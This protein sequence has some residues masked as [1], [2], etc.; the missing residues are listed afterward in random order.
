M[1]TADASP[2]Q[3]FR[4]L[5]QVSLRTVTAHIG[6]VV[7][8][9]MVITGFSGQELL[10]T[11]FLLLPPLLLIGGLGP[12]MLLKW[13]V[14]R[15]LREPDP[16]E[17]PA[18]RLD[19]ILRLPQA[20]EGGLIALTALGAAIYAAVPTFYYP[21]K[22]AWAIPWSVVIVV[23]LGMLSGIHTRLMIEQVLRP[24]A[25]AEFQ[26]HPEFDLEGT[27]FT[28]PRYRWY[29]PYAFG[30]FI[31]C[32]LTV[33]FT[34]LGREAYPV[35]LRVLQQVDAMPQG[36]A[37]P[38]LRA[39]VGQ[40]LEASALPLLLLNSYV[41]VVATLSALSLARHLSEGA[42][43]VQ[44]SME[45]LAAGA[46][47][48]PQWSSTDE[49]G[50][51]A[52]AT[53]RAF[54]KLRDFSLSLRDSAGALKNSAEQLG[55]STTK[56]TEVL[57]L[58]AS[59][60]Q[61][62]QVTAQEIKQTSAMA[63][64]KAENVLRQT[65]RANE[66]SQVG[67]QAIQRTLDGLKAIQGQVNEMASRIRALDERARQIGRI[68]ESVKS[69]ADRS[70]ML[71][72]NAAIEAV[73]SGE[74][75]KGF[76][77]VAREIRSLA[78]QSI[79]ATH[80]VSIILEDISEAIRTTAAITEEG[81]AKVGTSLGEIREFGETLQQLSNIVRDNA[82]SVRQIT[83]AVNQQG[84]GI[85]QIFQAVTDLSTMMDQ[86]MAQLNTSMS[87]VDLVRDV[88]HQVSN[89]LGNYG[90]QQKQQDPESH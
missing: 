68:T 59:A 42:R 24:H 54:A 85:T 23:L 33:S 12:H 10:G 87:A 30:L 32:A 16:T 45:A 74:H 82:Q 31:L 61:E 65:E 49:I 37:S 41:L 81:S 90:W 39:A 64:Q 88:S 83:T 8:L 56:Q 40:V 5:N 25:I 36:Q 77:V 6:P 44:A 58:Q 86:T 21:G 17:S 28:W 70:N 84:T 22:S 69:L 51:L 50:D 26:R 11:L 1:Q 20:Y 73:R 29:L 43:S 71:A 63:S 79:K 46:P 75:G 14:T 52:A 80:N 35:Y 2:Q 76:G 13:M 19:R 38:I 4:Q 57:T 89:F 62:T 47:M 72:L 9:L 3:V 18:A 60:L 55:M 67:E 48:L 7:Y 78:D 15:T 34:V 66:I 27:G 53:A